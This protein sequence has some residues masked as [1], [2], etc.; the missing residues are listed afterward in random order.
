MSRASLP[1]LHF[2]G[3][4]DPGR[5]R[6]LNED[7]LAIRAEYGFAIV[8]DG[9]GGYNAGE[10]ASGIAT[11]VLSESLEERLQDPIATRGDVRHL[12]RMMVDCVQHASASI[13]EAARQE[14]RYQGMGTTLV[15]ALFHAGGVSIAHVGDSRAYRFRNGELTR[16]TRDHS[17]LQ[18]QLDAGLITPEQ[19]R[20][21][22]DR[23][24]VT[25]A[26][27]VDAEVQVDIHVQDVRAQDIFLLCSDGLN[28]ML[29]DQRIAAILHA[30]SRSLETACEYLIDAANQRGGLDNIAVVLVR[31]DAKATDKSSGII[32]RLSDWLSS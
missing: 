22:V 29:S 19:A 23:N 12:H 2:A 17:F 30:Q 28:E 5:V 15:A 8:A 16:L 13:H 9:M 3:K 14:P 10:V 27:G 18:E 4:T 24:I 26:L 31:V 25:R 32:D 20:N 21:S 1:T 6:A 7:A 11:S